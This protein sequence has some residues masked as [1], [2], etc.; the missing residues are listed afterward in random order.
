VAPIDTTLVLAG[1]ATVDDSLD[2]L[3]G[4][5]MVRG[6]LGRI[7]GDEREQAIADVRSALAERHVPDVGVTLGA[8][9]WLV[10]AHN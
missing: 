2:F 1:G 4:M 7:D 3:L 10:S 9:G 8:A 5:G 6:L